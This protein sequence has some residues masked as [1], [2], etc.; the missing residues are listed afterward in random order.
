[1]FS[2]VIGITSSSAPIITDQSPGID[3]S[4]TNRPGPPNNDNRPPATS[5]FDDLSDLKLATLRAE[6]MGEVTVTK[7]N[8]PDTKYSNLAN[9]DMH[10]EDS[11]SFVSMPQFNEM[12]ERE[13]VPNDRISQFLSDDDNV[14]DSI[15]GGGMSKGTKM[16]DE[17]E[18][19]EEE[20]ET[21]EHYEEIIFRGLTPLCCDL[22]LGNRDIIGPLSKNCIDLLSEA[23]KLIHSAFGK[24]YN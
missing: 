21:E 10:I 3:S 20:V 19:H 4:H 8:S 2:F 1:M 23:I 17:L 5:S 16:N 22:V 13:D 18:I 24:I 6:L 12:E 7:N 9:D 11:L 14:F 15:D